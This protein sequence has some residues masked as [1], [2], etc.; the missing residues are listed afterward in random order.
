MLASHRTDEMGIK[1]DWS[2][3]TKKYFNWRIVISRLADPFGPLYSNVKARTIKELKGM[4]S[5]ICS[6]AALHNIKKEQ[7]NHDELIVPQPEP[8]STTAYTYTYSAYTVPS[9][10]QLLIQI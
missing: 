8:R 2:C 1:F 5:E 6:L 9:S 3:S 4:Y 7:G 10:I